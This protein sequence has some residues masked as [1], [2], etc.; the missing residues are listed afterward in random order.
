[1]GKLQANTKLKGHKVLNV[2]RRNFDSVLKSLGPRLSTT[3][4]NR[5]GDDPGAELKVDLHFEKLAD[6]E[7]N[8]VAKQV[9]PLKELL[10]LRSR[11]ADLRDAVQRNQ[12]TRTIPVRRNR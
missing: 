2:D 9:P 1:M 4:K 6:F 3:V 5:L 8:S 12:Q 11:L 10:D 7:P